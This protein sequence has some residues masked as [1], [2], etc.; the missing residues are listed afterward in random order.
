MAWRAD[1]SPRM[2]LPFTRQPV[3][4]AA[5]RTKAT[6]LWHSLLA[7]WIVL[8]TVP[9]GAVD[10]RVDVVPK[11]QDETLQF[12]SLGYTSAQ[13]QRLSVTRL[14]FLL[15][16]IEIKPRAGDWLTQKDWVA[17]LSL[18]E[19][20]TGFTLKGLPP[21]DYVAL[22]FH[23][24]VRPDL[25]KADATQF[26]A[27]HPL[28]PSVNTLWW[29][30]MGGYVFFAVEGGWRRPD[31]SLSG[32]SFHVATD[33]HLMQVELPCELALD[34][35]RSM[36]IKLDV[37]AVLKAVMFKDDEST[38][39]SR[40][41]DP[42][43]DKLHQNIEHAFQ[44][45]P[46]SLNEEAQLPASLSAPIKKAVAPEGETLV[47]FTFSKAFP[48]P[49]LPGDNPLTQEGIARGKKL[50]H[51][52]R[53]SINNT[54]ACAD[55]HDARHGFSD[56]RTFSLGAEGKPGTRQA[57]P[58]FNLAWKQS[59]FWDGRAPTLREQVLQPI[60]NPI[61]MHETLEGVEKK[62]GMTRD[63]IARSL[64][65]YLLTLVS[66]EAKF[67]RVMRGTEKFTAA[68]QRGFD[69]F[70]AEYDPRRGMFGAD[71]FH[72]HGGPLFQSTAFANNGLD[73]SPRDLGR[74]E[75]TKKD[76]DKG[77]FAVP[78]LRNVA[79]TA[80]YMHDGRF[81]TL[82][83]VIDHYDHGLQRSE[84]L[85]PNLAKHPLK[86]LGLSEEDKAALVAFMRTLTDETLV[87]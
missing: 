4:L 59:F 20:R 10:L 29:G 76:G 2:H 49:Q 80:P 45:M 48:I 51:D 42:L 33:K 67:D 12:D 39:H 56:P 53:L 73:V 35:S 11:F 55:C 47:P 28:N 46:L 30:W 41:D 71:C 75:V 44:A 65:Q 57:M 7:L 50:F 61:E 72:C 3:L 18:R 58:V 38:T 66:Q 78:S 63:Q 17:Y 22:R 27:G 37:A 74:F 23:V 62:L 1:D 24:G 54:Q 40:D 60:Q 86:G 84:A 8:L 68:E 21:G 16:E 69:L 52:K 25:N 15:S 81:T 9:A 36:K 82:E 87:K 34:R 14:D 43:A 64:E 19:N 26:P 85:D 77:K 79:L 31:G 13:Q 83:Q 5:M 70:H 6:A 32:Y